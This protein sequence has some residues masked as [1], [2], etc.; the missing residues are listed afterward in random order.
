M[1]STRGFWGKAFRHWRVA[2]VY[3]ISHSVFG[4]GAYIAAAFVAAIVAFGIPKKFGL[5]TMDQELPWWFGPMAS[6]VFAFIAVTLIHV[7]VIGPYRA[8]RMLNPF[9]IKILSGEIDTPYPKERFDRQSCAVSIRNK[10]Y[11]DW[12]NCTLHVLSVA[13]FNNEHHTFPRLIREFS[14]QSG[15]DIVIPFLSRVV[16]PAPFNSDNHLTFHGPVSMAWNG[17]RA[18]LPLGSYDMELRIGVPDGDAISMLCRIYSDSESIK[19]L[20]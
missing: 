2:V 6:V 11:R 20:R 8:Y 4:W 15:D 10:S 13:G 17:N 3:G 12:N 19:V 1:V 14:V 5:I 9:K 18:V 7:F 16:R